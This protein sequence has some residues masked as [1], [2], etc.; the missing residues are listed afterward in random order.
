[1]KKDYFI[2]FTCGYGILVFAECLADAL[3][4]AHAIHKGYSLP[5]LDSIKLP[6]RETVIQGHAA[7]SF[8]AVIPKHTYHD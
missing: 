5:L 1:M 6:E 3:A 7:K 8:D 2:K 4:K